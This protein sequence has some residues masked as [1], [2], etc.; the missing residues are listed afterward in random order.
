[1]PGS[2]QRVDIDLLEQIALRMA[3]AQRLPMGSGF[4]Q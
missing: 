4:A 1:M 3:P 2:D